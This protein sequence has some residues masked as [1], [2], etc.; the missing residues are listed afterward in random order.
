MGLTRSGLVLAGLLIIALVVMVA[1]VWAT[2]VTLNP[3]DSIQGAINNA[4]AGD[5]IVLNPGTYNQN[6]IKVSKDIT[7]EANTSAG[8]SPAN[9]IIDA[10]GKWMLSSVSNSF[11]VDNLSLKNGCGGYGGAINAVGDLTI[12][13]STFTHFKAS[14][15]SSWGGAVYVK[16]TLAIDSSTFTDCWANQGGAIYSEHGGTIV[17]STFSGCSSG[18]G[19]AIDSP[20]DQ[21]L[22]VSGSSFNNCSATGRSDNSGGA[23]YAR[24]SVTIEN[25]TID[26]CKATYEGGGISSTGTV[27]IE[28]SSFDNCEAAIVGGG[29]IYSEH[30]GTI[31]NTNF[32]T[33]SAWN[34]GAIDSPNDQPLT[35]S[36]S[37]F[38]NCSATGI[39]TDGKGGAI[40]AKDL[41]V[42]GSTFNSCSALRGG[43]IYSS[44]VQLLTVS[45]ST[46]NSCSAGWGGAI[47]SEHGSDIGNTTFSTCSA[48]RDGGG[49]FSVV[50]LHITYSSFVKCS[51]EHASAI[52]VLGNFMYDDSTISNLNGCTVWRDGKPVTF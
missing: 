46:F 11:V 36:G 29:A 52:Y 31:S 40:Y 33:C 44:G 43:G 25:S 26:N 16:G 20:N 34:G 3:G 35:V 49:I 51:A 7:L 42:S 5:A 38:I 24:G 18:W 45:G 17:N 14:L 41:T 39:V 19:G 28:N 50:K 32:S 23:I 9:T 30:G 8:G 6:G 22:T 15:P 10:Q 47:N 27:T 4:S 13:H 37:S 48:A 2:R 21:P 1:P 12:L